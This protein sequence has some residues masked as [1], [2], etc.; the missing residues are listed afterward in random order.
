MMVEG[1][2]HQKK[3]TDSVQTALGFFPN[4]TEKQVNVAAEQRAA[5]RRAA[6]TNSTVS[7][8]SYFPTKSHFTNM[9][10]VHTVTRTVLNVKLIS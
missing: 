8:A 4:T 3:V 2:Y 7:Y 5:L 6:D 1:K 9:L 10:I